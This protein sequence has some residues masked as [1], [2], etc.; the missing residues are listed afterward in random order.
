MNATPGL[1]GLVEQLRAAGFRVD[2]RQYLTAHELLLSVAARGRRLED[3]AEALVSHLGPVFCTSPEEQARF[4]EVARAWLGPPAPKLRHRRLRPP[5]P[6]AAWRHRRW[7]LPLAV[8][9]LIALIGGTAILV[10]YYR[11]LILTGQVQAQTDRAA[12][13]PLPDAMLN[14]AERRVAVDARGGFRLSLRRADG[15]RDLSVELAGYL[16]QVVPVDADTPQPLI[17]TL[18]PRPPT[19]VPEPAPQAPLSFGRPL[20][21]AHPASPAPTAIRTVA[22]WRSAAA[23]GAAVAI[24]TFFLWALAEWWRRR[25]V[26]RRLPAEGRPDIKT[27]A[28]D[29]QAPA[30]LDDK[31]FRRLVADLRRPRSQA[32][33]D[34]DVRGTVRASARRAGLFQAVWRPRR[35]MPEYLALIGRHDPE[36]HQAR[37][38]DELMERLAGRGVAVDAL[39]FRD[40]PRLC[41]SEDGAHTGLGELGVRHHRAVLFLFAET[42]RCFNP[43][44]GEPEPWLETCAVWPRR[45]LFTPEPVAHWT[46]QAWRLAESGW[47]VLPAGE[48]GLQLYAGIGGD[49]RIERLF[50]APYA[51]PFPPLLAARPE[52]WLDRNP[53]PAASIEKLVRQLHAYLGDDGFAWLAACAVYPEIA[54]PVTLRLW[55]ALPHAAGRQTRLAEL[56]PALARLPWFRSGSMPDWLRTTLIAMLAPEQEKAVRRSLE[57]LLEQVASHAQPAAEAGGLRIGR[58]IGPL[59]VL[60]TAPADSPLRDAVF[61]GYIGRTNLDRLSV[62]APRALGRL[63]REVGMLPTGPGEVLSAARGLLARWA[64]RIRGWLTF[65][66]ALSRSVVSAV[67]GA[68]VLALLG[69][70]LTRESVQPLTGQPTGFTALAL[71]PDGGQLATA[72]HDHLARIWDAATGRQ[73]A[74]LEGH[75][76]SVLDVAFSPDGQRLVSASYDGTAKIWDA[77]SGTLQ[78]VLEGHE[79][80]VRSAGFSPDGTRV[81]TSSD[82]G[83]ARVWDATTGRQLG[84]LSARPQAVLDGAYSPDGRLVALALASGAVL[85]GPPLPESGQ[86]GA[87]KSWTVTPPASGAALSVAFSP[88]SQRLLVAYDDGGARI[89]DVAGGKEL[90]HLVGVGTHVQRAAYS[91]DGRWVATARDDGS[92]AVWD[93]A[94]GR[95]LTRLPGSGQQ[96]LAAVFGPDAASLATLTAGEALIW[97][98]AV[99]P[100]EAAPTPA[101][102][103]KVAPRVEPAARIT[104]FSARPEAV[105]PGD[106]VQLCYVTENAESLNIAP[107][108]GRLKP[109]PRQCVAVVPKAT[110]TYTLTATG[111]D[112]RSVRRGV[113][114]Q[115]QSAEEWVP[116]PSLFGLSWDEARKVLA[117]AG[118]RE[119]GVVSKVGITSAQ[120]GTV[121]DQSPL[122]GPVPPGSKV[123]LTLA[124]RPVQSTAQPPSQGWCCLPPQVNQQIQQQQIAPAGQVFPA[125]EKECLGRGGRFFPDQ[126]RAEAACVPRPEEKVRTPELP[127]GWRDMNVVEVQGLLARAGFYKGPQDGVVRDELIK[128]LM[129]FQE[130]NG[131]APDG[132]PDPQTL[133][134]LRGP[135]KSGS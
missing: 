45:V 27:L 93:A 111:A 51:R 7:L 32:V 67:L 12:P 61:L 57:Q 127:A 20:V 23:A 42:G 112:G 132:L 121:I 70:G 128:A 44:S 41:F 48:T 73:A 26:L 94:D 5:R 125:D 114:V 35:A 80:A 64:A 110:T 37:L 120:L 83:T 2:T 117:K 89:W 59:D 97:P 90:I 107:A 74:L 56:L 40:D 109:L 29:A 115:V 105:A 17:L 102:V 103:P 24:L 30:V 39:Y 81:L 62:L 3:D 21:I 118:L 78:R 6:F 47:L 18:L 92:V 77:A 19:P 99:H 68:G 60:R 101:R 55:D 91:P 131:I 58:W 122:F 33:L 36:D 53:P 16:P 31:G 69:A 50:P 130:A 100:P 87:W 126:G 79:G 13:E 65:H 10:H 88:D 1:T 15:V 116:V 34:L 106:R 4:P 98:V 11:P 75:A 124:G 133:S 119:G 14:L 43:I 22:D 95:Q 82:D 71:S 9:L 72:S 28:A 54:W 49:W 84:E 63:F 129:M 96:A 66:P 38:A 134:V 123:D 85:G 46:R 76:G 8:L 104:S 113:T 52:R 108:V 135:A 25:L 86:P